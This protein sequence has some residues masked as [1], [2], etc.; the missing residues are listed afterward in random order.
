MP[1][2]KHLLGSG[3]LSLVLSGCNTLGS[4]SGGV[5]GCLSLESDL[6]WGALSGLSANLH[7]P[8]RLYTVHDHNL[9]PPEIL[10]IELDPTQAQI[11]ESIPVSR[12]QRRPKYDL[13]GIAK[14]WNE[15]FWLASEGKP[16]QKRPN[17][18]VRTDAQGRVL[19]EVPLPPALTRYRVKAGL[20]GIAAW[21]SNDRERV[22]VVFQRSW[23]DDP[24]GQVKI[25]QYWPATGQWEFYRYPLDAGKGLG[26]SGI[27]YLP[28]GSALVLERDNRPFLKARIKRLYRVALPARPQSGRDRYPLLEKQPVLDILAVYP[29]VCGNNGK[30][31]GMATT[32]GGKIYLVADDDGDG[33]ARLIRTNLP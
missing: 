25:G 4:K 21:G 32:P 16:G 28:D 19:E 23:R 5:M 2:L 26:L 9:S 33:S 6:D 27:S 14:R 12:D 3:L 31:E 29:L 11:T 17:L 7:D 15:G 8:N 13:E 10:V 30:L 20:E 18:I 1:A 24:R 22:A